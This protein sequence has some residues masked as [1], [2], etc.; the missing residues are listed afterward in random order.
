MEQLDPIPLIFHDT[1]LNIG[2]ISCRGYLILNI[3]SR[4]SI[5]GIQ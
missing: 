5:G 4:E 2:N 1:K 3:V